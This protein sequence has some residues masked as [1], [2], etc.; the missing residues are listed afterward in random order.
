MQRVMKWVLDPI[1]LIWGVVREME[2]GL[3]IGKYV[4]FKER[5]EAGKGESTVFREKEK[6]GGKSDQTFTEGSRGAYECSL[7]CYS[8]PSYVRRNRNLQ[9]RQRAGDTQASNTGLVRLERRST[10]VWWEGTADA[11]KPRRVA[12]QVQIPAPASSVV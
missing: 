4:I 9:G 2:C 7:D 5:G 3:W 11:P 1:W 8:P 6:E 12:A 10:Q